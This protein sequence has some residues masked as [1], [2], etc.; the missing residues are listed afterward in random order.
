[1]VTGT[2]AYIANGNTLPS[3]FAWRTTDNINVP[4]T[5]DDMKALG[6]ALFERTSYLY[7]ASWTHKAN[8]ESLNTANHTAQDI[9]SYDI[10][11][12]W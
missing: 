12:G 8:L 1:M 11:L 4:F 10:T 3:G 9:L 5:A 6:K 2:I 7:A